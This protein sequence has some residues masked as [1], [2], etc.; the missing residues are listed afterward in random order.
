[1]KQPRRKQIQ[2]FSQNRWHGKCKLLG[3]L[4]A[5]QAS[6]PHWRKPHAHAT[7][8]T[9]EGSRKDQQDQ[10]LSQTCGKVQEEN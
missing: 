10:L 6:A 8:P 4:L 3:Q 1:M 5:W 2:S 9:R 7:A